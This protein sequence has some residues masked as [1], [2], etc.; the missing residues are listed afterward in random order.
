MK[1]QASIKP[2]VKSLASPC[3][4]TGD[5][6]CWAVEVPEIQCVSVVGFPGREE[7]RQARHQGGEYT[8]WRGP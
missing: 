4:F 7:H 1:V 2:S 6:T 5:C 8:F 3:H